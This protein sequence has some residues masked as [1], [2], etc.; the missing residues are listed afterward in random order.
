MSYNIVIC[1]YIHFYMSIYRSI[2]VSRPS[3][4]R[5]L[6]RTRP[7]RIVWAVE[8]RWRGPLGGRGARGHFSQ[9]E[10]RAPSLSQH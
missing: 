6:D 4:A 3:G 10:A 5:E 1:I 9:P 8:R 7:N 2:S